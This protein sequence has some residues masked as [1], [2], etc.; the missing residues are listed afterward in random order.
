MESKYLLELSELVWGCGNGFSC[1]KA[2]VRAEEAANRLQK[3]CKDRRPLVSITILNPRCSL[4][5]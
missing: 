3:K 5:K 4:N 1:H 2:M